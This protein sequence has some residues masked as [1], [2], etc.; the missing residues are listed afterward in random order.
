MGDKPEIAFSFEQQSLMQIKHL[1][2]KSLLVVTDFSEAAHNAT[3]YGA[4]LARAFNAKLFL[5]SAYLQLP[6]PYAETPVMISAEDMSN[7]VNYKLKQ[8]VRNICL[9][10]SK[11]SDRNAE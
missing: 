7:L 5:F 2:M 3:M 10:D 1:E 6:V 9:N 11:L 8:E 4:A